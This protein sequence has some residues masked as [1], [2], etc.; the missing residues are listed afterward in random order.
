M[1]SLF[2]VLVCLT[3]QVMDYSYGAQYETFI[4]S[5]E[6]DHNHP[7]ITACPWYNKSG[8]VSNLTANNDNIIQF[9]CQNTLFSKNVFPASINH[10]FVSPFGPCYTCLFKYSEKDDLRKNNHAVYKIDWKMEPSNE[11][12][13][14]FIII[15]HM[16][17]LP[18]FDGSADIFHGTARPYRD[19]T[20]EYITFLSDTNNNGQKYN[21]CYLDCLHD[22]DETG[23]RMTTYQG[24]SHSLFFSN[25]TIH[26]CQTHCIKSDLTFLYG[27]YGRSAYHIFNSSV[28]IKYIKRGSGKGYF[29]LRSLLTNVQKREVMKKYTL[30]E[31]FND[32][33]SLLGF[34]IGFSLYNSLKNLMK[35]DTKLPES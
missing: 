2:F 24:S 17:D 26:K 20:L 34:C 25:D 4:E 18:L 11:P 7:I 9:Q 12:E 23:A 10:G 1:V 27:N 8:D 28:K 6:T 19:F 31:L 5:R 35:I 30:T 3:N 22:L 33:G 15:H 16:N 32:I 21:K 14:I 29:R 13:Y